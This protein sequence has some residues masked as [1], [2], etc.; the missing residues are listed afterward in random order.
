MIVLIYS[1][2]AEKKSPYPGSAKRE[3]GR[4]LSFLWLEPSDTNLANTTK[5]EKVQPA[6]SNKQRDV[7]TAYAETMEGYKHAYRREAGTKGLEISKPYNV[8]RNSAA[9]NESQATK[10]GPTRKGSSEFVFAQSVVVGGT[11]KKAQLKKASEAG[12]VCKL[13]IEEVIVV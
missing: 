2:S 7:L 9:E 3:C 13:E 8:T 1:C 12:K 10:T 6:T 5:A 11:T 4:S